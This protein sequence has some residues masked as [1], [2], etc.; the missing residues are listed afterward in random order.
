MVD[1]MYFGLPGAI[2]E[3][4]CP[5][6]GMGFVSNVDN[7]EIELVSGGRS[8]YRAATAFKT[9]NMSWAANSAKLRHLID[10]YNGQFGR[11]PFYFTDPSASQ[12]NILPPRWSNAWQLGYQS[13]GWGRPTITPWPSSQI[14]NAFQYKTNKRVTFRQAPVGTTTPVEGVLRTRHIRIPGQAY[15]FNAQGVSTGGAGVKVR[16]YDASTDSWDLMSTQT[17]LN[18]TS[19]EVI[20]A[21]NTSHSMIELDIY[22]PLGSTLMLY[23]MTLGTENYQVTDVNNFMPAGQGI[24]AVNFTGAADGNLVSSRIDRIGLSLD[25]TEVQNVEMRVI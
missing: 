11:G 17:A 7:E 24:G 1:T 22:L 23:G 3:I 19:V 20:A 16:A 5:E 21:G 12:K 8:V 4:R 9:F 6:S 25:F 13:N 18:G 10:C 2:E 15:R 14:P